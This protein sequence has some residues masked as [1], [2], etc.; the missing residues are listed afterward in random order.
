M[1]TKKLLSVALGA[2]MLCPGL[3]AELG[4]KEALYCVGAGTAS[5][6]TAGAATFMSL[7]AVAFTGKAVEDEV[8][9]QKNEKL[10]KEAEEKV[11]KGEWEKDE[12]WSLST[13]YYPKAGQRKDGVCISNMSAPRWP[14]RALPAIEYA[15]T[16]G[17]LGY[18]AWQCLK[19]VLSVINKDDKKK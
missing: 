18:A 7:A 3:K 8:A 10:R 6:V 11:K 5:V 15:T 19:G 9:Y 13:S 4:L 12:S 14:Q 17:V 2:L 16:A 1:N